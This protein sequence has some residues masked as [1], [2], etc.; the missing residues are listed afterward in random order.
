MGAKSTAESDQYESFL[1]H[2]SLAQTQVQAFIRSLVH[3]RTAADDVYQATS[4]A[5]WRKFPTFRADAEFLHWA[6]GVARKEVLLYWR[7]RRRDRLVFSE[8]VLSQLA[9]VAHELSLDADPRQEALVA[10]MEKLSAR[11]RQL[12]DLFYGQ[13]RSA[14]AIAVSWDRT[15]H[16]VYKALKVMRR[17]LM[18]C[19]DRTLADQS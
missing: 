8:A 12:F 6:L 18:D 15:V 17:N 10:C 11:Q 7:S 13:R 14:D 5:L 3:D 4:L 2:Y 1:A 9:D 16:A 19:V